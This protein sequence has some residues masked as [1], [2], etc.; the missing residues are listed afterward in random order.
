M[1]LWSK[2]GDF[3]CVLSTYGKSRL[4]KRTTGCAIIFTRWNTVSPKSVASKL[5]KPSNFEIVWFVQKVTAAAFAKLGRARGKR[6]LL[7]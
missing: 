2:I 6:S 3:F 4:Q 1:L 7:D 5:R